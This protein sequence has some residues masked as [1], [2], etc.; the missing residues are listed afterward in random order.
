V[1]AEGAVS[2][3]GGGKKVLSLREEGIAR[4]RPGKKRRGKSKGRILFNKNHE[5]VSKNSAKKGGPSA[6]GGGAQNQGRKVQKFCVLLRHKKKKKTKH[7][8]KPRRKGREHPSGT[9]RKKTTGKSREGQIK[10][11]DV[12]QSKETV[13]EGRDAGGG[14]ARVVQNIGGKRP[15][16]GKIRESSFV[17]TGAELPGGE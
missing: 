16:E 1:R 13:L 15:N 7:N 12:N 5:S 9:S 2:S 14:W 8:P 6:G 17:G 11:D 3:Q 4:V 10:V